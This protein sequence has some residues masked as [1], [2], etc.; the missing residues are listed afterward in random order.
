MIWPVLREIIGGLL[1]RHAVREGNQSLREDKSRI[2][3]F[4]WRVK[5][6]PLSSVYPR[7]WYQLL[8][9]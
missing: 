7:N 1:P 9:K 6:Q 3:I 2:N 4:G 5:R 8:E